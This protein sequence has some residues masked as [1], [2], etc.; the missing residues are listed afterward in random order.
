MAMV[1]N[2]NIYSQIL[3]IPVERKRQGNFSP[4]LFSVFLPEDHFIAGGAGGGT[5]F[6]IGFIDCK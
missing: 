1:S 2:F 3:N 5:M 4:A 6:S